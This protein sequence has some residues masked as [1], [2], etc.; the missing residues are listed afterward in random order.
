MI[1]QSK[2]DSQQGHSRKEIFDALDLTVHRTADMPKEMRQRILDTLPT[3]E[4]I[5]A[6]KWNDEL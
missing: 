5:A 6:D 1:K 4:E 3:T 2:S